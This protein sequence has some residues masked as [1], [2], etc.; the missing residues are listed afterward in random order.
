[1]M[2]VK[3]QCRGNEEHSSEGIAVTGDSTVGLLVSVK[4]VAEWLYG[5]MHS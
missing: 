4:C 2:L 1:M 3:Q 5:S